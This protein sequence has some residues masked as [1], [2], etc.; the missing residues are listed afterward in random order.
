MKMTPLLD[1]AERDKR[2]YNLAFEYLLKTDRRVTLEII[3]KHLT[4]PPRPNDIRIIFRRVI[5]SAKNGGMKPNVI[6]KDKDIDNLKEIL[7]GYNP[8]TIIQ[9][10]HGNSQELLDC[11]IIEK[12]KMGRTIS[13]TPRSIWRSYCRSIIE[14]AYF[15]NRFS[16]PQEFHDF[17]SIFH[18]NPV[19][20][21]AL[22]LL[23][24][25]E[26]HGFGFALACDFLKEIGYQN[27][28][29]P[30]TYLKEILPKLELSKNCDDLVV[31]RAVTRIAANAA[32]T[33]FAVDKLF[34]LIGSG[35]FYLSD[36]EIGRHTDDFIDWAKP[37][38]K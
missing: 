30:D 16:T 32:T 6:G 12:A 11:F 25:E 22:P 7:C 23:L 18:D 38:L 9:Y 14:G 1:T 2:A 8:S 17:V 4:T 3:K 10:Y 21:P 15:L 34:W 31:F 28:S 26:I 20:L 19:A 35:K 27:F 29:K 13:T 5:M 24:A 37:K 36:L 33:A